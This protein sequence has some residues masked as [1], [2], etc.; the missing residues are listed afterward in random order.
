M[1][2]GA[3]DENANPNYSGM[4]PIGYIPPVGDE[5]SKLMAKVLDRSDM[6]SNANLAEAAQN[7]M[8]Q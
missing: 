1:M 4:I 2:N 3:T 8:N 5:T 7:F 6:M